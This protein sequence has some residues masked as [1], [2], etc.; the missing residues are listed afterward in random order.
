MKQ[1]TWLKCKY[2]FDVILLIVLALMYE[3]NALGMSFHEIGGLALIG[4][5]LIH[6]LFN[7]RWVIGAAKRLFKR[8]CPVRIKLS[9][10]LSTGLFISFLLIL[11][12]GIGMSKVVFRDSGFVFGGKTIHY[13]CAALALLCVG[14]HV[15]LHAKQI[16]TFF[17]RHGV[18]IAA[19][20]L[21]CVLLSFGIYGLVS[22]SV[23]R[24]LLMPFSSAEEGMRGQGRPEEKQ[25]TDSATLSDETAEGTA[26]GN[27]HGTA[28]GAKPAGSERVGGDHGLAI[29]ISP[30]N[31]LRV[32]AQYTGIA[33]LLAVLAALPILIKRKHPA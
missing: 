23:P 5:F 31:V 11:L 14:G 27:G 22:S 20:A 17:K 15:G 28:A 12:S 29:T 9:F 30:L 8:D 33:L 13:F 3:K 25:L 6:I 10:L 32:I 1:K 7:W 16:L 21:L 26:S 2:G 4:F 18:R 24:Y 19:F